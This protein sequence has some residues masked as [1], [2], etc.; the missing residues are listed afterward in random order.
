MIFEEVYTPVG[1]H[2]GDGCNTKSFFAKHILLVLRCVSVEVVSDGFSYYFG[3]SIFPLRVQIL[4]H[5]TDY[6]TF[7]VRAP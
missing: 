4:K 7:G 1:R 6:L 5:K 2:F 3:H